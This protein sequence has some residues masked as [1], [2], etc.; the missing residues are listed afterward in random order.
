MIDLLIIIYAAVLWVVFKVFAEVAIY[1]ENWT[2]FSIVRRVLLRM[3]S[4][5][6]FIFIGG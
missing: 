2:A 3:K 1:S 6:K 4:W 5:Q